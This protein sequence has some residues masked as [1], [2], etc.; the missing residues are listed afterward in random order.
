MIRESNFRSLGA[1][2][3]LQTLFGANVDTTGALLSSDLRNG[4]PVGPSG[5]GSQSLGAALHA[6]GGILAA[7]AAST[8]STARAASPLHVGTELQRW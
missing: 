6:T 1:S 4:K 7:G 5:F 8:A 3:V 2:A